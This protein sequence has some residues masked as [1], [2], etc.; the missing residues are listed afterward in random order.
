MPSVRAGESRKDFTSRC[1]PIVIAEGTAKD[2]SQANAICNSMYDRKSMKLETVDMLN[3]HIAELKNWKGKGLDLTEERVKE[4]IKNFRNGEAKPYLNLDHNPGMTE[5][6]KEF[7][8]AN[9]LGYIKDLRLEGK[10]LMA[11]FEKVPKLIAELID[12]GP[13]QQRSI[14]YWKDNFPHADG[15]KL[16]NILE[17]VTFHGANGLPAMNTLDDIPKLF[18][19]C[20]VGDEYKIKSIEHDGDKI[21][22]PFKQE[23]NSMTDEEKKVMSD[24]KAD[25]KKSNDDFS[26]AAKRADKAELKNDKS[27][28]DESVKL[29]AELNNVNEKLE[30]KEKEL[31]DVNEKIEAEEKKAV[32]MKTETDKSES[33]KYIGEQVDAQTVLPCDVEMEKQIYI[34]M[35]NTGEKELEQYKTSM[36]NRNKVIDFSTKTKGLDENSDGKTDAESI[37]MKNQ[38]IALKLNST[39]EA[40]ELGKAFD[41]VDEQT[42][43]IMKSD[44]I[45]FIE[46]SEKLNRIA[47]GT[48]VAI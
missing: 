12:A 17:A 44:K 46:A 4:A 14:E 7:F 41:E 3:I 38:R 9:S 32:E 29:K 26:E 48:E 8:K 16:S 33:E 27:D 5:S 13:L 25:L 45:G 34:T 31:D 10:K 42:K 21:S 43:I 28:T 6:M 30:T 23:E 40:S 47:D 22:I 15:R 20:G 24:L 1:I 2:G 19:S 36:S 35:K 11:D 18:K 37:Q 39:Y